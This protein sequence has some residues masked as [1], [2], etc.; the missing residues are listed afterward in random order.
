MPAASRIVGARSYN[1]ANPEEVYPF[2]KPCPDIAKG[3]LM[4]SS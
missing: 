4:L 3:I 1:L 2:L